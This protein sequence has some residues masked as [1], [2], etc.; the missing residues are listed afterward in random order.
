MFSSNPG[1]KSDPA[2]QGETR[3]VDQCQDQL[4]QCP[5]TVSAQ[6]TDAV[7][8][9]NVTSLGIGPAFAIVQSFLAQSQAQSVLF[10]NMVQEHQQLGTAGLAATVQSV[11]Q[12]LGVGGSGQSGGQ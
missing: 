8:Q 3:P 6:I 5:L 11:I 12:L 4:R 1:E 7:T 2:P 9:A 10:A